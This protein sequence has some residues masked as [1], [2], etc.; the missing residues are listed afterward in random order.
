M[1]NRMK[2]LLEAISSV[3]GKKATPASGAFKASPASIS[4][5]ASFLSSEY[6]DDL[7]FNTDKESNLEFK[8]VCDDNE[9]S[10]LGSLLETIKTQQKS[11]KKIQLELDGSIPSYG[12][13]KTV[14][15]VLVP[16]SAS[17]FIKKYEPLLK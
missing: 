10:K 15:T 5:R 13:N 1:N 4:F 7:G 16:M 14:Y 8:I 2:Y 6:N 11:G 3:K 9:V 12:D 17:E